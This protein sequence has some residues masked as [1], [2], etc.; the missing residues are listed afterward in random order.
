MVTLHHIAFAADPVGI[1]G[2]GPWQ[3]GG[4]ERAVEEADVDDDR[5]GGGQRAGAQQAAE[6]LGG[7]LVEAIEDQHAF[8]MRDGGEEGGQCHAARSASVRCGATAMPVRA[9][10]AAASSTAITASAWMAGTGLRAVPAM[11]AA[12]PA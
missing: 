4:E 3:C 10:S 11:A 7:V 1:V 6:R 2:D 12:M 9:D 5:R 8:L